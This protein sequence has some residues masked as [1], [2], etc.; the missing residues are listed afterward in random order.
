MSWEHVRCVVLN[1]A[2]EPLN[3]VPVKKAL[4]MFF[5]GKAVIVEEHPKITLRSAHDIWALPVQ[6]KLHHFVKVR[7]TFRV[8]AKLTH[9]DKLFTRD[10]YTCQYCG[11]H[12]KQLKATERLTRDHIHPRDKGGLDTWENVTTA[13]STCNNKKA[14]HSLTEANMKLLRM[15]HT[16]TVFELQSKVNSKYMFEDDYEEDES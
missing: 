15:P 6:V 12:K 11:R 2:Y 7:P 8:P 5:E 14:N 16:P 4:K 1:S 13:C 9:N 3:F 10:N